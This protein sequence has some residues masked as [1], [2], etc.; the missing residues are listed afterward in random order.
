MI[1]YFF[2]IFNWINLALTKVIYLFRVFPPFCFI[3]LI[4]PFFL[5]YFS[6]AHADTPIEL[7]QDLNQDVVRI[8][9]RRIFMTS[10]G[11]DRVQNN[12]QYLSQLAKAERSKYPKMISVDELNDIA[13]YL[14]E[15]VR[16]QGYTFDTIFL[17]AQRIRGG[18]VN[19][20]YVKATLSQVNVINHT[21]LNSK[22]ISKPFEAFMHKALYTKDLEK[23][24]YALQAQSEVRI[25][26]F[27]SKGRSP[28]KVILNLRVDSRK[29][30]TY[31]L[32][33]ENFG[34]KTTG[35][36]QLIGEFS[37]RSLLFDFDS[38]SV[39]LLNTQGRGESTYGSIRYS[40]LFSGLKTEASVMA[41]NSRYLLGDS[42]ATLKMSGESRTARVSLNHQFNQSPRHHHSVNM[43]LY[44]KN[45]DLTSDF[46]R[47]L[48]R[49]ESSEAITLSY[50]GRHANRD[51]GWQI[52]YGL[53][54][55]DGIF[56]STI[57]SDGNENDFQK[58]EYHAF[59][60]KKIA[61]SKNS[62][63]EP[64]LLLRGQRTNEEP[65]PGIES[66]NIGGYYGVRSVPVGAISADDA[67]IASLELRFFPGLL[68][69]GDTS[70]GRRWQLSPYLFLDAAKGKKYQQAL[71]DDVM[72]ISGSGLG[73]NLRWRKL[74]VN[75]TYAKTNSGATPGADSDDQV[76]FQVRWQ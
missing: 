20:T 37:S 6:Y 72:N 69:S 18:T 30:N 73:L 53:N 32:R 60:K 43:T 51:N 11:D 24:V 19:F 66:V 27:Y 58:L 61:L 52:G 28:E 34:S 15:F 45:S 8:D 12:L 41:G 47:T 68:K 2:G 49:T 7:R 31:S 70:S 42:L 50:R 13:A 59:A 71:P 21:Q 54:V 10:N 74:A 3:R 25:F 33:A 23:I 44:K 57:I 22:T 62:E 67:D 55:V 75:V 46:S 5:C 4:F 56:T 63:F 40:Y 38:L 1:I 76:L 35:E 16:K 36:N 39:A 29:A 65:V 48:D 64:S 17:P 14:T 9:V 26:A